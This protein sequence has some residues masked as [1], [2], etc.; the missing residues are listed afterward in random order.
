[1]LMWDAARGALV[2]RACGDLS[3]RTGRPA[4]EGPI[5]AVDSAARCIAVHMYSGELGVRRWAVSRPALWHSF[6]LP[7]LRFTT[8]LRPPSQA[9]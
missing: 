9:W 5:A 8:S 6:V 1:M 7:P 2:T 3:D 4:D